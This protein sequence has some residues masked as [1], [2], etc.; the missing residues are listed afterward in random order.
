MRAAHELLARDG[1]DALTMRALARRLGVSPNALYSHVA[2]KTALVDELLDDLLADVEA[3]DSQAEDWQAGLRTIMASTHA[4]LLTRPDLVPIYLAR[5]GA[6][7]PNARR[8]GDVM[9][10]LLAR[11]GITGAPAVD[12]QRA[13]IVHAIGSAAFTS[14]DPAA[15]GPRPELVHT[16]DRGLDWLLAGIA[17]SVSPAPG[18]RRA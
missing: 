12:A 3:P 7:G 9:L 16:F 1:L 11:G 5:Q 4:V 13:L 8:L 18:R 17:A 15:G 14:G 6:R 2:T 10:E